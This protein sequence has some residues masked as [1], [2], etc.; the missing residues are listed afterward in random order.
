[1]RTKRLEQSWTTTKR[2]ASRRTWV[3]SSHVRTG[4]KLMKCTLQQDTDLDNQARERLGAIVS[5][6]RDP[7]V[8]AASQSSATD[9]SL[10]RRHHHLQ[11][12]APEDLPEESRGLITR[13]IQFFRERAIKRA[14]EKREQREEKIS[15]GYYNQGASQA[16][17]SGGAGPSRQNG[18]AGGP[19]SDRGWG[20]GPRGYGNH[21]AQGS[22][23]GRSGSF[24]QGGPPGHQDPQS[25][26]RPVDFVRA[27]QQAAAQAPITGQD[28]APLTDAEEE[29][30]RAERRRQANLSEYRDRERRWLGRERTR[31]QALAR[32]AHRDRTAQLAEGDRRSSMRERLALWDDEVELEKGRELFLTDRARWRAQ[33][34]QIR[35]RE[36]ADDRMDVEQE[37][38]QIEAAKRESEAFLSQQ[39]D[40]FANSGDDAAQRGGLLQ[41]D[42]GVPIKLSFGGTKVAVSTNATTVKKE[43]GGVLLAADDDEVFKR[44]RELI[45]LTYDD[46][47]E[48]KGM[49]EEEKLERRQ[50]KVREIV[51]SIPS[52]KAALFEKDLRWEK[53]NDVCPIPSL[54]RSGI[55]ADRPRE[56]RQSWKR[57]SGHLPTRRL[58]STLVCRTTSL[59]EQS[60]DMWDATKVRKHWSTNSSQCSL[61][62]PRSS[63]SSSVSFPLSPGRPPSIKC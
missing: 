52:E 40:L 28:G 47:D 14:S 33:R 11:D 50:K 35:E 58:S 23:H 56:H 62:R 43:A 8:L 1:M 63:S 51:A 4:W 16:V 20:S 45:P 25:F 53:L 12:L 61:R 18:P 6:M 49:T 37:R 38:R 30:H 31:G 34:R 26:N 13:E 32:E 21:Q 22:P 46:I 55:G 41:L 36:A 19:Q 15:S 10:D 57:S 29:Q 48:E 54:V 24:N 44:K 3:L 60:S 27:A 5:Q 2:L 9:D 59:S 17:P 39:A 7:S 42:D